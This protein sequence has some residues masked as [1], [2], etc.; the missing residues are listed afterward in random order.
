MRF[1]IT[2]PSVQFPFPDSSSRLSC[3]GINGQ[4]PGWRPRVLQG[5]AAIVIRGRE[6]SLHVCIVEIF[7][8]HGTG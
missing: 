4:C 8:T 3:S 7:D 5:V 1:C 6:E 2:C